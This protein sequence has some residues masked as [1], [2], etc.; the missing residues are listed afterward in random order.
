MNLGTSMNDEFCEAIRKLQERI[1]NIH[2]ERP[3]P[4]CR[5]PKGYRCVHL[6]RRT[7][8]KHPHVERYRDLMR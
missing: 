1:A 5:Q 8:N 7:F 3:C 6:T 4:K 2:T